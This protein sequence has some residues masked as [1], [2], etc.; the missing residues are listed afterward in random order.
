MPPPSVYADEKAKQ[1]RGELHLAFNPQL[2]AERL[3]CSR[4]CDRYNAAGEVSRRRLVELWR[5]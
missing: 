2:L 4:A 3:R 1:L 5:E